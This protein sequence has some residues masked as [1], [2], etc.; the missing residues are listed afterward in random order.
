MIKFCLFIAIEFIIKVTTSRWFTI[1]IVDRKFVIYRYSTIGRINI[2]YGDAFCR[3]YSTEFYT[4]KD[5][6]FDFKARFLK[7]YSK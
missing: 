1:T 2:E 5:A 7:Y 6:I 4:K 3:M